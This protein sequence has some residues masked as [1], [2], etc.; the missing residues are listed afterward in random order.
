VSIGAA[1]LTRHEMFLAAALLIAYVGSARTAVRFVLGLAP[2]A[3]FWGVYNWVRF[4]SP[5]ESGYL[6]DPVVGFGGS[7]SS[8]AAGLLFSPYAS[9]F[10]YCPIALLSIA[11]L[12]A[13]W[14]HDRAAATLFVALFVS[15][16]LLYASLGNW[17]AGRSYGPRFLVPLLPA[18]VLPLA[19]WRP[20]ARRTGIAV[21]AIAGLSILVQV[22]GVLVDYSKVRV[23]LARAGA[24]VAQD[25][26]WSRAPLLLN[27]RAAIEDVPPALAALAGLRPVD[28]VPAAATNLNEALAGKPDLWWNSLLCLGV[29]G[30]GAAAAIALALLASGLFALARAYALS[31]LSDARAMSWL[32]A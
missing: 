14:R 32:G 28:R 18:L 17:M 7:L 22:P 26:R 15:F 25:L 5:F 31:A 4:G 8:G 29:I 20:G 21:L 6:R 30:R 12:I 2:M 11:G 1:A 23:T 16:F 13:L 24:T 27:T 10:L 3:A 9:L 19:W